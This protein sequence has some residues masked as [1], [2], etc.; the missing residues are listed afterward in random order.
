M[1]L[2][3]ISMICSSPLLRNGLPFV[4]FRQALG[5]L[6]VT[7]PSLCFMARRHE[8]R[9]GVEDIRGLN[10]DM[11]VCTQ[12]SILPVS[13]ISVAVYQGHITQMG[14]QVFASFLKCAT[15]DCRA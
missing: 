3:S 5:T 13:A 4:G 6:G 14:L 7:I 15:Q 1:A 2:S 10:R 12:D 9:L 8:S 11:H